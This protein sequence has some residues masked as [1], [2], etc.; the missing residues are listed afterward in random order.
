MGDLGI[1]GQI[2]LFV[3]P[4]AKLS[5]EYQGSSSKKRGILAPIVD[6]YVILSEFMKQM[7]VISPY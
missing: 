5:H 4:E 6:G 7:I 3:N 1:L 2:Q